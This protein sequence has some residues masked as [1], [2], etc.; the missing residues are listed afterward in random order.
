M[1]IRVPPLGTKVIPIKSKSYWVVRV[2]FFSLGRGAQIH[3]AHRRPPA[4][5]RISGRA[6]PVDAGRAGLFLRMARVRCG[7]PADCA[8]A[9]RG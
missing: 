2:L 1:T 6:A 4:H 8:A 5:R 9:L 3:A 7:V